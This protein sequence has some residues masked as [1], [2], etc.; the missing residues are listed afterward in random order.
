MHYNK[1]YEFYTRVRCDLRLY[2][3]ANIIKNY[4][5]LVSCCFESTCGFV[6]IT[7]TRLSY[8][9]LEISF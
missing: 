1:N 3:N 7:G 5:D 9:N 8:I 2:L 4:Y 6:D